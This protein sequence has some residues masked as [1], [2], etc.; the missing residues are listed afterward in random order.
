MRTII[1]GSREVTDYALVLEAACNSGFKITEIVSGGARGVDR[2][3]EQ[4]GE[5]FSI[6]IIR[7]IPDWAKYGNGAGHLRNTEMAEY[8]QALIAIWDGYSPGTKNMINT[9][10]RLG[11]KVYIE[12]A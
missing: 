2:L 4:L 8:A 12:M 9:A 5:E 7:F 3:G 6:P 10:K 1:A 11:L